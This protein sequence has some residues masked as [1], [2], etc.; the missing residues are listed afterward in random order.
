MRFPDFV[1]ALTAASVHCR[2][3][4]RRCAGDRSAVVTRLHCHRENVRRRKPVAVTKADPPASFA[5]QR[6]G[7]GD[8]AGL[9]FASHE[10]HR[11]VVEQTGHHPELVDDIGIIITQLCRMNGTSPWSGMR[12]HL[13]HRVNDQIAWLITVILQGWH[14]L[15]LRPQKTATGGGMG[16]QRLRCVQIGHRLNCSSGH[17]IFRAC[18]GGEFRRTLF[19]SRIIR[20]AQQESGKP[21]QACRP[22]R[23]D[24]VRVLSFLL[25]ALRSRRGR[26]VLRGNCGSNSMKSSN[27]SRRGGSPTVDSLSR[28]KQEYPSTV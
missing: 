11:A 22:C 6:I 20:M 2:G 24:S 25:L 18:S 13:R 1:R 21:G 16:I 4:A 5:E 9:A 7:A 17:L 12:T 15:P 26:A 8:H 3:A 23:R 27:P 14:P 10:Q 28:S 19:C